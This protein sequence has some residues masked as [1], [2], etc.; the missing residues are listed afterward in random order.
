[1]NAKQPQ[2]AI[3]SLDAALKKDPGDKVALFWKAMLEDRAG[4]SDKAALVY[5]SILKDQPIKDLGAGLT[6][7]TAAKWALADMALQNHDIEGAI[8]RFEGLLKGG[9]AGKLERAAAGGWSRRTR[10]RARRPWPDP[11]SS[12]SWPPPTRSPRIG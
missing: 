8:T 2:A 4:A 1:M 12:N 5:E 11:R 3:A 6:L 10:P 7:T 9:N